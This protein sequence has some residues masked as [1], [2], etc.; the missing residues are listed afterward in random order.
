MNKAL[1]PITT[2]V[3]CAGSRNLSLIQKLTNNFEL[4]IIP[5]FE[6]REA[7][8]FALGLAK[9]LRRPVAVVCTSGTAVSE[10]YSAVIEAHYQKIPLVIISAD[11]PARY[12][13]TGAPQSIEQN[14]IF[15]LYAAQSYDVSEA[16]FTI[17]HLVVK[18]DGPVHF[19]VCVE[20]AAV[21]KEPTVPVAFRGIQNFLDGV[22]NP[23]VILGEIDIE[24]QRYVESWCAEF[25]ASIY[26]E[27]LSGLRESVRL[28]KQLIKGSDRC[29]KKLLE[30][31]HFDGVIRLGGVPTL[32]A[33]RD[34][35]EY[36]IP[37]ISIDHRPFAG[38]TA[39]SIHT[40]ECTT[41]LPRL[42]L[43]K[44]FMPSS[45]TMQLDTRAVKQLAHLLYTYPE[46]EPALLYSLSHHI[47]SNDW[48]FLGN[49]M[50]IREWDL[51]A[52]RK[53]P[54]PLINAQ[55]G[56]N[57]I[58]GQL[59]NFFGSLDGNRHNW[60]IFGDLTMLYGLS[61]LSILKVFPSVPI[62]LIV[63]N[64]RGGDIFRRL[65]SLQRS[66]KEN[67]KLEELILNEHE[68]DFEN[69]AK[70]W[71]MNFERTSKLDKPLR[72]LGKKLIEV[73]P[74]ALQTELFWN[75]W[76]IFWDSI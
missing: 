14:N 60:G 58:D 45:A 66:F 35:E 30:Q 20:D 19:N 74:N 25:G 63:I 69:V 42:G 71:G 6:E 11:R 75:A 27:A 59:S 15:G 33:W 64:N 55:R 46:S 24:Q 67:P 53:L 2:F 17:E 68:L 26:A 50:P 52:S 28:D 41:L 72:T 56:T 5:H 65:P 44:K 38:S 8:F 37:V 16:E 36:A 3:V 22:R 1:S 29:V 39:S 62:C 57:G 73:C 43:D 40:E 4:K 31:R 47:Q 51:T 32:R 54:H 12:R 49:S 13:G 18:G 9:K 21:L 23:L 7:S 61:S 34:L 48:I 70:L 10:C 76:N